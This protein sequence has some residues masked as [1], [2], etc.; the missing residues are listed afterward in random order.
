ME[1]IEEQRTLGKTVIFSTHIM[2]EAEYLCDRIT[3]LHEGRAVDTGTLAELLLHTGAKNLT[4]AF[5]HHV[6]RAAE[7]P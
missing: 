4:D 1:F 2:S 6:E 5:L 7:A 3:L